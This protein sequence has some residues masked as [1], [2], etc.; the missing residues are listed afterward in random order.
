MTASRKHLENFATSQGSSGR[1][2]GPT[3][4]S[5]QI[6]PVQVSLSGAGPTCLPVSSATKAPCQQCCAISHM[7]M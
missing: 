3:K 1:S 7:T 6:I 4:S 5:G 2:L